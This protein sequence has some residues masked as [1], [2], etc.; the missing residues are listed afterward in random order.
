MIHP[1]VQLGMGA[2]DSLVKIRHLKCGLL[3]TEVYYTPEEF[4]AGFRKTIAFRPRVIKQNRGSQGEGIWICKLKDESKYCA[5]YG[6]AIV[7]LDEKLVLAEAYDNHIEEHSVEEFIEF[8][9]Y[10]HTQKSGMWLSQGRGMYLDGG[11]EVG[12]M[13]VDQRF[14]P[15]IVEGEVRCNI[16]GSKLVELVHKKPRD[17]CFSAT[18]S[19]GAIYTVHTPD[20]PKFKNLVAALEEDLPKIMGAV[21]LAEH[22]LPLLWS[23]DYIFG[24]QDEEGN[25]TFHVGEFN[26][27]CVGITK[28]A[29]LCELVGKT[30][31]ERA[32]GEY[33]V[34]NYV[35]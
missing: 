2:K 25:A 35:I 5:N 21:G 4:I 12:A 32:L 28:Q 7:D 33:H 14:L 17:G 9:L 26:S 13:L 1:D 15:R 27:T 34:S 24:E 22:P 8:C 30:A 19:S 16:V 18:L 29:E 6:D 3:D 11:L 10:G 31:V 20:A 23:V